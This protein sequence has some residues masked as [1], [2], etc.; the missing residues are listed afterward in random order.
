MEAVSRKTI[1]RKAS[2]S[3]YIQRGIAIFFVICAHCSYYDSKI[4]RISALL[5]TIGV[6]IF[7]ILSGFFS[8]RIS[9]N[10]L[11]LRKISRD[12][13][14]PWLV[15]GVIT[16]CISILGGNENNSFSSFVL[17]VI[18][19]HTWLYYVPC[20]VVCKII[21]QFIK[22]RCL[23]SVLILAGIFQ[24]VLITIWEKNILF[25]T[26]Y[27][28]ILFWL[29]FYSMGVLMREM[30]VFL[31]EPEGQR[32]KLIVTGCLFVWLSQIYLGLIEPT[33]FN[34]ISFIYEIIAFAFIYYLSFLIVQS[35]V[36]NTILS[37][38]GKESYFIYFFHMQIAKNIVDLLTGGLFAN[39]EGLCNVWVIVARPA[40]MLLASHLSYRLIIAIASKLKIRNKLWILGI[41]SQV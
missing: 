23:N 15:W 31:K 20:L 37:K 8:Y 4:Q 35:K 30:K 40:F 7:F 36:L 16:Y 19:Y 11:F 18:G 2:D 12:I 27:Q 1:S 9:D 33:Y 5:G 41:K 13:I 38:I 3:F 22:L 39:L 17:W 14:I 29:P 21:Y 25:G 24:Y 10:K 6:P 28:N 34:I 32:R 26:L